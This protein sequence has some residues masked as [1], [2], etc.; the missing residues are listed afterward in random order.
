[1]ASV[2]DRPPETMPERE[3]PANRL[4]W[5]DRPDSAA[6]H[7]MISGAVWFVLGAIAG[8]VASNELTMPDLFA[9]VPELVFS[10]L[11]P[12][13][14][15]I[16][17]FG[18]LSTSFFGAWYYIVPRLCQT[19]L[20][21]NRMANIM[22]VLWNIGIL[23]GSISLMLGWNKGHEYAEYPM[24]IDWIITA[25][26]IV[27]AYIFY[28]TLAARREPK[29]YV[30]LWYIGGTVMWI[31]ILY[32]IGNII[33]HPFTITLPNGEIQHS[34]ALYG[35]LDDAIWQWFYGHNVFGLYITTGGI[36]I[37]YYMVPKITKQPL[38]AHIMS[39]IGFWSIALLYAPT[40]QHHL[41]QNPIPNW[42]KVYATIGSVALIIPVFTFTTNIFMTMN[43]VWG[44]MI[45]NIPLR[46]IISG[47]FMYM[48]VSVQGS[49][50]SLMTVNRFV[51]Y[52]QWV[53]AHA[54]LALLGG[55]GFIAAGAILWMV[56][57]VAKRDLWSRNWA[58]AQYWLMLLGIAGYFWSITCAGLA[59]SSAWVQ[60]G[61][62]EVRAFEVLKPYFWMR[63]WFGGMVLVGAIMML[64]NVI[65]TVVL[66][67][68]NEAGAKRRREIA[69]L[70]D[71]RPAPEHIAVAE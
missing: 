33:W 64:V 34:G 54:H 10:R 53:I 23:A 56:P 37:V 43:K 52:T 19:R 69:D 18:F 22:L 7:G 29:L 35:G 30:S 44:M 16:M 25:L 15:N 65:L 71:I 41:L 9:G 3:E 62:Q 31:P 24:A 26:M 51:H 49:I 14:V 46:F 1:M 61:Q 6:L 12:V 50:Q 63:S 27:N 40:G 48:A 42:L 58:D 11:R 21:T 32:A 67:S 17:L 68:P 55:F 59:Q 45:E 20:Q 60:L 38:Y 57:L 39:L 4:S 5:I 8:F 28:A 70:Q 13:H 66:P 47:A 2:I 36:A